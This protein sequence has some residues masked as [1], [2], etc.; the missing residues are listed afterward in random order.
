MKEAKH[1]YKSRGY[2]Y[3]FAPEH[4]K[5]DHNGYVKRATL[6]MEQKL[7]RLLLDGELVHHKGDSDDDRPE[8]L[9]VKASQSQHAKDHNLGGRVSTTWTKDTVPRPIFTEITYQKLSNHAKNRQRNSKGRF[10]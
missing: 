4:P 8:M 1:E 6:A 9:E 2:V 5:A 7:G 10:V 3:I